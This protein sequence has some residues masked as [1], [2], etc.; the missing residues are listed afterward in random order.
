MKWVVK[1]TLHFG[2][3]LVLHLMR[4]GKGRATK[5]LITKTFFRIISSLNQKAIVYSKHIH[6]SKK[7]K[8]FYWFLNIYC[9]VCQYTIYNSPKIHTYLQN[10]INHAKKITY[11]KQNKLSLAHAIFLQKKCFVYYIPLS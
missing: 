3:K 9:K 5:I 1:M 10:I 2:H 6:H 4:Q 8:F 7:E 11:I